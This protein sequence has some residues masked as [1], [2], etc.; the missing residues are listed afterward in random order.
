MS[1]KTKLFVLLALVSL[2][3]AA[4]ATGCSSECVDDTDC[5]LKF[6]NDAGTT[7]YYCSNDNTC[8]KG[9]PP[10]TNPDGGV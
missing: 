2:P 9:T 7:D 10:V 3:L 1:K 6:P 4:L 5:L 8:V